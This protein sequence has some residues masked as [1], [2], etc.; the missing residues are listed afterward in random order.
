MDRFFGG[1]GWIETRVREHF[2]ATVV[3][4]VVFVGLHQIWGYG[5]GTAVSRWDW[6]FWMA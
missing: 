2:A 1:V 3:L 6:L 4:G 5:Y